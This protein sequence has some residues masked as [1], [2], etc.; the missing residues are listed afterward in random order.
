M[1]GASWYFMDLSTVKK[2]SIKSLSNDKR[3]TNTL[4]NHITVQTMYATQKV[5]N[6]Y[7][8]MVFTCVLFLQIV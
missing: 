6:V 3:S 2:Y 5:H 7:C 8:I 4:E 1:T